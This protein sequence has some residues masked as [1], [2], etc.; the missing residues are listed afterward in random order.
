M[1]TK[2]FQIGIYG[3]GRYLN[4]G[5]PLINFHIFNITISMFN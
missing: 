1:S 3:K 4:K 5:T 2:K